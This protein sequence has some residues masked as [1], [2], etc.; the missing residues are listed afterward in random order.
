M[1]KQMIGTILIAS[2]VLIAVLFL[3]TDALGIG[4]RP[5]FGW[6]QIAGTAIGATIALVG[7]WMALRQPKI[8]K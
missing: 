6:Y 3:V 4:A 7:I 1:T 5:G 2:W 8:G